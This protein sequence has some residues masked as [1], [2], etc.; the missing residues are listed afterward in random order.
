M[1]ATGRQS[2]SG[3][4]PSSLLCSA[5]LASSWGESLWLFSALRTPLP[6]VRDLGRSLRC[7]A[8]AGSPSIEWLGEEYDSHN[9]P[10]I[11][12]AAQWPLFESRVDEM[13][14]LEGTSEAILFHPPH[15]TDGET[16]APSELLSE[17][18]L[19]YRFHFSHSF[20][21]HQA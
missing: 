17:L 10:R 3:Q 13:S 1:L 15:F 2:L 11:R 4:D 18:G 21:Q 16:E 9:N 20:S 14:Q 6:S 7:E 5:G 12:W 19:K 8:G